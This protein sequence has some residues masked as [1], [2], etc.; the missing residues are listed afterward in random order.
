MHLILNLESTHLLFFHDQH[1]YLGAP[2]VVIISM[3]IQAR[4]DS[5]CLVANGKELLIWQQICHLQFPMFNA[6]IELGTS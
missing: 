1:F 2:G 6:L 3:L 5:N 4:Q